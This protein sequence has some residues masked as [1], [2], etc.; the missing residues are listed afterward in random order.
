MNRRA[1]LLFAAVLAVVLIPG[2]SLRAHQKKEP[3]EVQISELTPTQTG[4]NITLRHIDSGKSIHMVIGYA[5]GQSIIQAMRGRQRSRPMT[6]DLM[7][8]FL[9]RNNW[10]VDRVLIRDLVEGTFRAHL[11]LV[12]DDETQIFD[13]RPS[14]AMAIG[15]RFGA[16]IFVNEEVFE[17][18]EEYDEPPVEEKSPKPDTLR[19]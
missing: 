5:E 1:C 16:R 2:L 17:Q 14:D 15:L 11:I 19:L 3:V 6:H 4:V 18:Q 13:A 9:E 8:N 12:R 7:K 10:K